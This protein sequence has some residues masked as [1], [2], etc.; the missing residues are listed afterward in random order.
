MNRTGFATLREQFD[1]D[2]KGKVEQNQLITDAVTEAAKREP[3]VLI[4]S[5]MVK[6]EVEKRFKTENPGAK[7]PFF[8]S[9]AA[10]EVLA[11]VGQ[12]INNEM[13]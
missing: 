9:N 1:R 12:V 3:E 7:V 5:M 6:A 8:S 11:A 13:P 4:Y 2:G 10:L